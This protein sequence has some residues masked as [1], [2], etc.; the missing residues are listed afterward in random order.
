V[1]CCSCA[2]WLATDALRRPM[3]QKRSMPMQSATRRWM[4]PNKIYTMRAGAQNRP[5][6]LR[7]VSTIRNAP[8]H[9]TR[10]V[11]HTV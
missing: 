4:T 5:G 6:S 8:K 3:R 11:M 10:G 2:R 9:G 1:L 7:K